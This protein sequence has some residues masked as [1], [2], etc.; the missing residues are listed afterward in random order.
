LTNIKKY[1]LQQK[2]VFT[3]ERYNLGIQ[4]VVKRQN[5]NTYLKEAGIEYI[6]NG[7]KILL[8]LKEFWNIIKYYI[9]KTITKL[10]L[11]FELIRNEISFLRYFSNLKTLVINDYDVL[12]PKDIEK[13]SKNTSIKEILV[14]NV[15]CYNHFY[16][17]NNFYLSQTPYFSLLYNG[18]TIKSR[19]E[20]IETEE[21]KKS[22]YNP[23]DTLKID[24]NDL[25]KSQLEKIFELSGDRFKKEIVI[26]TSNDSEYLI[27]FADE[28]T[29]ENINIKSKNV[30]DVNSFY[31]YL[32]NK[33]YKI[34][35]IWYDVMNMDY[36]NM[37][38]SI[39]EEVFKCTNL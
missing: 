1:I 6:Q 10:E 34:N 4:D 21:N 14:D 11:P 3:I 30:M 19:E 5:D 39:Y 24:A 37:D 13:I 38:L 29:I 33:G 7:L 20:K 28:K 9:P 15:Y 32:A 18:I 36:I 23:F 26:K 12:T 31:N 35:S 27:K 25:E 8:P 22:F 2:D 16:K 17:N